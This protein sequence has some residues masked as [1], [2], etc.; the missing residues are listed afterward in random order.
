MHFAF[1]TCVE[2]ECKAQNLQERLKHS[3]THQIHCAKPL[4][5]DIMEVRSFSTSSNSR[6]E[7]TT[8]IHH[9]N[10]IQITAITGYITVN[11]NGS[12][13][14]GYAKSVDHLEHTVTVMFL[15]PCTC[16]PSPSF[17]YPEPP[18]IMDVDPSD[19]LSKVDPVTATGRT[20]TLTKKE[21]TEAKRL[22]AER[23]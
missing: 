6:H 22:L 7:K 17:I 21:M 5:A 3:S 20:Y 11:Y 18:D 4:S 8:S 15:H 19:I 1:A 16:I 2:Y 14:L 23:Q 9:A 10:Q 13:W 12:C